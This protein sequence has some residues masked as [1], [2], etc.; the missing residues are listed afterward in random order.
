M[1]HGY[2]CSPS[3]SVRLLT[4]ILVI[5]GILTVIFG[6]FVYFFFPDSPIHANFLTHEER[7]KAILRIKE[8]HSGIEQ[9]VFKRYQSDPI[10]KKS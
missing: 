10:P 3:I 2:G 6:V 9:K 5:T 8:N 7:A 4:S 1:V